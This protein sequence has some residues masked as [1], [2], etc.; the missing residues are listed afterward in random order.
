MSEGTKEAEKTGSFREK[1][2]LKNKLDLRGK[3]D[4]EDMDLGIAMPSTKLEEYIRVLRL[5]RK[6]TREEFNMIA[7]ISMAGIGIIGMLGFV[8][9]ALL[10]E[11]P[12][13]I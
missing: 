1:L 6:P 4:L 5:A 11:L 9:Y 10:T 2:D 8:T 3:L 12:K 13:A 7:K